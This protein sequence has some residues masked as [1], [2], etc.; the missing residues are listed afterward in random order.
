MA[1][2]VNKHQFKNQILDANEIES[3]PLREFLFD[4]LERSDIAAY[5]SPECYELNFAITALKVALPLI[6]IHLK[7]VDYDKE[8]KTTCKVVDELHMLTTKLHFVGE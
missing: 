5:N 4:I 1:E 3:E 6:S 7:S 8:Y 2:V